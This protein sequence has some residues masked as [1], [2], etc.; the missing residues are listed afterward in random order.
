[1]SDPSDDEPFEPL[2]LQPARAS[3]TAATAA[4]EAIRR[5]LFTGFSCERKG[6]RVRRPVRRED[7]GVT[8]TRAL[9]CGEALTGCFK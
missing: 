2:W 8:L 9:I 5:G 1:M 6:V 4:R 7:D 3:P